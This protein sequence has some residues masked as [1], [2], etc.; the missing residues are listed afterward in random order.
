MKWQTQVITIITAGLFVVSVL[1]LIRKKNLKEEYSVL[2]LLAS[3][4]IIG[5]ALFAKQIIML[6]EFVNPASG[7]EI[8]FFLIIIAQL[9]FILLFSVKL[10]SVKDQNKSLAQNLA[11]MRDEI[12]KLKAGSEERTP[13]RIGKFAA[14]AVRKST[15]F[16]KRRV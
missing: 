8:L 12:R 11:L 3:V 16:A 4:V 15:P 13:R 9:G 7:G 14:G 10:S 1:F 2:W 6:F 5:A